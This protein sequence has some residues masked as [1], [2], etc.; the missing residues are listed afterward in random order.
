LSKYA[1]ISFADSDDF[2][3]WKRQKLLE[4][5]KEWEKEE[6]KHGAKKEGSIL[7]SIAKIFSPR[8]RR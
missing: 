4:V 8:R 3:F 7:K 1:G 5:A 2:H 6:R